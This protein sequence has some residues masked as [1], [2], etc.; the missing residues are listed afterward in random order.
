MLSSIRLL[1]KKKSINGPK[2]C[3]GSRKKRRI[4]Q[5]KLRSFR[6]NS[7]SWKSTAKVVEEVSAVG[8]RRPLKGAASQGLT[9]II[10]RRP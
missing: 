6:P 2:N 4:F 3:S 1:I 8:L 9:M 5:K 7:T 10:G